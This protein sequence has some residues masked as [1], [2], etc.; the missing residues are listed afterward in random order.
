MKIVI[1]PIQNILIILGLWTLTGGQTMNLYQTI[2]LYPLST[3]G[4]IQRYYFW[5]VCRRFRVQILDWTNTIF[6]ISY[7]SKIPLDTNLWGHQKQYF[8]LSVTWWDVQHQKDYQI[9]FFQLMSMSEI[10]RPKL[11]SPVKRFF[12]CTMFIVLSG[13]L[14]INRVPPI[15]MIIPWIIIKV[16]NELHV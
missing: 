7:S 12:G 15:L 1:F 5:L 11:T 14:W 2:R 10:D 6:D 4:L 9:I 3:W 8:I 13:Y 16:V